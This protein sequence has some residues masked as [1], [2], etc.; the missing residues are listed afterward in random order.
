MN[1]HIEALTHS[2]HK[3]LRLSKITS[4]SFA[5]NISSVKLSLSELRKASLYYPM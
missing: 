4:F 1:K 3:D 2:Q 5:A